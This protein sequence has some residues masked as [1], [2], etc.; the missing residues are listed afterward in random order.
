MK[1]DHSSVFY[2]SDT[3]TQENQYYLLSVHQLFHLTENKIHNYKNVFET[4][5]NLQ[6]VHWWF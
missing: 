6:T 1:C 3:V 2:Y 4:A 5:G